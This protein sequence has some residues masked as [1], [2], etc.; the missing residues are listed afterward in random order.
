MAEIPSPIRM[1]EPLPPWLTMAWRE[2]AQ[3]IR[4]GHPQI[5]EYFKFTGFNGR[6]TDNW[7]S[8]AMC[9]LM[10]HLGLEHPNSPTARHWLRVGEVLEEPR[11]GCIVVLWRISPQA[12]QGH[13]SLFVS[14]TETNLYL[15]GPNQSNAWQL[16]SYPKTR[17]LGYR[18]PK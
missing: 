1:P 7:C 14:E 8:A 4:T 11:E 16:S 9:Y 12:W 2:M 5:L 17:L 3:N 6:V 13:V 18:W 15:F 10:A